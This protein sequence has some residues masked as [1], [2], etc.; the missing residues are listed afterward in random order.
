MDGPFTCFFPWEE[1][2]DAFSSGS[3]AKFFLGIAEVQQ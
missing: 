1:L 3:L 2:G